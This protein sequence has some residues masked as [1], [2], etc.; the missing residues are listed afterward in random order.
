MVGAANFAESQTLAELYKIALTTAGFQATVLQSTNREVYEPALEK[1]DIS[2][3]PEYAATLTEF[4]NQKAN[5][6][7]AADHGQRRHQ[8]HHQ[9]AHPAR[10]TEYGLVVGK[11]RPRPT[12]TRSR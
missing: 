1:G 12:R 2:V 9:R 5:G 7:T 8:R 4:L 10:P 6:K 3:F 11:R